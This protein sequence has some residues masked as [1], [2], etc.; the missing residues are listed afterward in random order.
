MPLPNLD[1]KYT[2]GKRRIRLFRGQQPRFQLP[3]SLVILAAIGLLLWLVP[4]AAP[5]SHQP[6]QVTGFTP[7]PATF[8]PT[9][10]PVP[11]DVHGGLIVFTCTRGDTNQICAVHADGSG[12]SRL[13]NN[14]TNNYYPAFSPRGDSIVYASLVNGTFELFLM[15]LSN[16]KLFQL[17][18][19]IG[20]AFSPDFSPDGQQILFLNRAGDGPSSIWLMGKT[21]ENPHLLYAGSNNIVAA[22]W[23]PH[24]DSIA[25]AMAVTNYSYQIFLLDPNHPEQKPRQVTQSMNDIGGSLDWAPDGSNLLIYAGPVGGREVYRVDV[26]TGQVTQL[27][28]GGNNAAPSYSPDGQYIVY[29]SLRN[30]NQADLYIMRA[31]GHSTR[32]LTNDPEP[33]WQPK[34]GP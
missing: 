23:S 32:Q 11:T 4:T 7:P 34:W 30:N 26:Q 1:G 18:N 24:G 28:F 5:V 19:N 8:T 29:N 3:I 27:T 31:D 25:F 10:S 16:S 12:L 21:G 15:V 9:P 6:F 33:D 13:T 14:D 17:T 2:S 22:A 20:N